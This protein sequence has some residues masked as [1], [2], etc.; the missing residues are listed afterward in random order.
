MR[1]NSTWNL[2][3]VDLARIGFPLK[4]YYT[5]LGLHTIFDLRQYEYQHR[6]PIIKAAE[7]DIVI[8]AG[9]CWGDTALYF[10]NEVGRTGKVFTF[11]FIPDNLEIMER[12]L[13]LNPDVRNRIEVVQMALWSE[14]QQVL[15]CADKGAA[16]RVSFERLQN[17]DVPVPAVSIDD[18]V[19]RNRIERI[20][21]IKM[22]IEGAELNALRGLCAL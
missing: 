3:Y 8:D 21:F 5:A 20:D 16:T 10:A 9:G 12:N 22:D 4:L 6:S 1:A 19:D 2:A 17:A 11:E 14:S 13:A 15:Y 18:F 7:G